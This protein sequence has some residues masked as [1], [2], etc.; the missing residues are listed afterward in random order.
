[1]MLAAGLTASAAELELA[2]AMPVEV[3]PERVTVYVVGVA[4]LT[5]D[6]IVND[7]RRVVPTT[8]V[9]VV[10]V[11]VTA[12]PPPAGARVSV[13]LAGGI[14]PEGKFDPMRLIL[15]TPGSPALGDVVDTSVTA[16]GICDL[17]S[18]VQ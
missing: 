12:V 14:A 11:V 13:T 18:C 5:E 9:T 1:V 8:V 16:M 6:G 17:V 4:T 15:V 3:V 2:N 7:T 10:A